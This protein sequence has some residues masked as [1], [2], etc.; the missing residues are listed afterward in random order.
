M[1]LAEATRETSD[2]L[3]LLGGDEEDG[4]TELKT[5]V[6]WEGTGVTTGVAG[7]G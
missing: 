6:G 2:A 5:E 1:A 4:S 7:A 3:A